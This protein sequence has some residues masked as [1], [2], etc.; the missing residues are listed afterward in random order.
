MCFLQRHLKRL[1]AFS[2]ISHM[3]L[4]AS[5]FALLVPLGLAGT[6]VY[7]V[8]HG[9]VKG[10]LFICAGIV[11][12]ETESVD[13]LDLA[14]RPVASPFTIAV[15][16]AAALGLAG[17]PPFCT[18]LGKSYIEEAAQGGEAILLRVVMIAA[19]T[20]TA[21]AVLRAGG[22]IFF[23]WGKFSG[24]EKE[25]PTEKRTEPEAYARPLLPSVMLA[26]AAVLVTISLALGLLPSFGRYAVAASTELQNREMYAARVLEGQTPSL[27]VPQVAPHTSWTSGW[28][29][30][31][32]A[33]VIALFVLFGNGV[34]TTVSG[35]IHP[36]IN[37]LRR[38][39]SGVISDYIVW[40]VIGIA[41]LGLAL[42]LLLR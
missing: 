30:A 42:T 26:P 29:T 17:L 16:V 5:G 13:E 41:T 7:I 9:L 4:F 24:E 15:Y 12:N 20:I 10:A 6:A 27:E 3:G 37:L 14:S 28:V 2:T 11:L 34:P 19:S 40:M 23:G 31:G 36:A 38:V 1:L 33:V 32:A 8:G 21:A 25:A 22:R 35:A 18:A 39:H